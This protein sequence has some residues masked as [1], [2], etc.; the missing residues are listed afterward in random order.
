MARRESIKGRLGAGTDAL[1]SSSDDDVMSSMVSNRAEGDGVTGKP[2]TQDDVL[3][4]DRETSVPDSQLG[5]SPVGPRYS[6]LAEQPADLPVRQRGMKPVSQSGGEPASQ[7]VAKPAP[8]RSRTTAR[9]QASEPVILEPAKPVDLVKATF[10][11]TPELIMKLEEVR[12][13]RLRT[14]QRVDKSALVR[15]ALEQ[16]AG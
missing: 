3:E 8:Q 15:E 10:Y 6:M 9:L 1:F 4:A 2:V 11:L 5:G 14:G 12:M 7:P 13:A 16:L